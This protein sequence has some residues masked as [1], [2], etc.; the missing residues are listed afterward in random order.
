MPGL[1]DDLEVGFQHRV[2]RVVLRP[3]AE[4]LAVALPRRGLRPGPVV[5][6][7]VGHLAADHPPHTDELQR[8]A[9]GGVPLDADAGILPVAE[10]ADAVGVLVSDVDPAG[11]GPVPVDDGDLPVVPVVEIKPVHIL[12]DGVEDL[13]LDAAVLN[14][15]EH[16]VREPGDVA[17]VV[18]DDLDLHPGSGPLPE[19]CEDPIPDLPLRQ[20]VVLQENVSLGLCQ[21]LDK[22]IEEGRPV[23][24]VL[25]V[26][27][28]VEPKAPLL[29]VGRHSPPVGKLPVEADQI[30]FA[31]LDDGTALRGHGDHLQAEALGLVHPA[32]ETEKDDA[33][34]RHEKEKTHP[35]ELVGGA[36]GAGVD[37]DGEARAHDLQ[38]AV[39][40]AGLLLQ[41]GGEGQGGKDLQQ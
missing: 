7:L 22:V 14:G 6:Q 27:I 41:Q 29:E 13:Q 3:V 38:R 35:A 4:G 10:T 31:A 8:K 18:K 9:P 32:P 24:E 23:P 19:D 16:R 34:H 33:R 5:V 12:V 26:G 11:V 30:R 25:R 40:I 36:S 2:I 20:D 15:L 28:A 21:V 1:A 17:E 37:P 39:D